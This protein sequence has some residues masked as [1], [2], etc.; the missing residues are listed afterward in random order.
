MRRRVCIAGQYQ[1]SYQD[2]SK[3][4]K[5]MVSDI[6]SR[7]NLIEWVT[8][9]N[10]CHLHLTPCYLAIFEKLPQRIMLEPFQLQGR[11]ETLLFKGSSF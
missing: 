4:K 1:C 3:A 6:T 5:V 2:D 11:T 9:Q 10:A 8:T 7:I